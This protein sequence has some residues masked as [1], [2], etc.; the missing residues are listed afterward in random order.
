M[1]EKLRFAARISHVNELTLRGSADLEFWVK[2]LE[3]E[4]L[5][6]TAKNGRA[7]VLIVAADMRYF[8]IRFQEVSFS[9]LAHVQNRTGRGNGAFLLQAFNSRRFFAWVERTRFSTPYAYARFR[10]SRGQTS[11]GIEV[12]RGNSCLF[13]ATLGSVAERPISPDA[14]QGWSGLIYLPVAPRRPDETRRAFYAEVAGLTLRIPFM[15]EHDSIAI[16]TDSEFSALSAL[17]K[18]DVVIENWIMRPDADHA[19]SMTY[20]RDE[21]AKLTKRAFR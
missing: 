13:R 20:G 14:S 4:G 10:G 1:P 11:P 21:L 8:G 12:H 18:S 15:P 6:P 5:V 3:P 2:Q 16:D 7:Q 19:K 9:I 17:S